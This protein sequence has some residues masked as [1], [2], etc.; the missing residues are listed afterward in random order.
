MPDARRRS[1]LIMLAIC[2]A[3][4][5]AWS[6][7]AQPPAPAQPD[8]PPL[9]RS[10]FDQL[11]GNAPVPYPYSR[12]AQIIQA[13]MQPDPGGMPTLKTTLIPL[14]RS[15]QKNAGA[16]DFFRFPRVVAAADGLNKP[17]VAPLQDRLFLGFHEKGEVIEVISY[18]DTA[19]RFEFQ[20]VRDYAP[21][22]T[23]QVFYARRNLCLACHQNAAPIFARPLWDETPANPEIARRLRA[24]RR[25]FY[26]VKLSGTDIAYFIDAATERA[27]LFSV[28]QT[29][30]QQA[31]GEGETGDRCRMEAFA[32][33]LDYARSG[34]L[35]AANALPTLDLNWK[36][37]WPQ[38]LPIPNPDL[39]NRDPLAAM[40]D[41]AND[42]LLPR[43]PLEIWKAPDKTAFIVGLAGMLDA[44]V[45]K[46]STLKQ[47][48]QRDLSAALERLRARGELGARPFS[49]SLLHALQ[50]E[51]GMARKIA[52][53]RLPIARTEAASQISGA[54]ALFRTQCGLCHDSTA[55]FPPNFLHG[56]DAAVSA[57]L[58]HCAERIYYRLSMWH[59]AETRRGK[60]PMPPPSILAAR[61]IDTETWTHSPAMAALLEDVRLRIRAQNGQ[62]EALL[63]RRFEQLRACLPDPVAP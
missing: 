50:A 54:H 26:G 12:L 22:K 33:A 53:L 43:P 40:P 44:A 7:P 18:N 21:G 47:L 57:R 10:R 37:R 32:A 48:R 19:G 39:P 20:V 9:G 28:W 63:A 56:D 52:P 4:S 58:D 24:T 35:P 42:P 38:G 25:D 55:N 6:H 60:S 41:A 34:S 46:Q 5:P 16:P 59:I 49:L 30:W 11:I 62:P 51:L 17:G 14:G 8:L 23:P 29:L 15:L 3:L 45:V 27:N 1:C 13:Q 36:T 2:L 61:G 31:C